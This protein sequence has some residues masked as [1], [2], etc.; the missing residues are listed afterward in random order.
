MLEFLNIIEPLT[1]PPNMAGLPRR[2]SPCHTQ[3][4][5]FGFS[6]KPT[7]AGCGVERIA[8]MW[9]ELM[10]R[11]GYNTYIAQGG[12]WGSLVTHALL[13]ACGHPLLGWSH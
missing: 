13:L 11:F 3:P 2:L 7:A 5:G 9:D 10:L 4:P 12:D 1:T 6:G 8:A